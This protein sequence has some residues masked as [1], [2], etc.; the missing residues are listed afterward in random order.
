LKPISNKLPINDPLY[1]ESLIK[2]E[3]DKTRAMAIY[4]H[5]ISSLKKV[6]SEQLDKNEKWPMLIPLL[7]LYSLGTLGV[8]ALVFTYL[9]IQLN[10]W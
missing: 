1:E 9:G 2:A 6:N 7:I 5:K 8:L 3:G 10:W 4:R